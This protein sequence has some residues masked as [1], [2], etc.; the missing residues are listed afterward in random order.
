MLCMILHI[1]DLMHIHTLV[2]HSL[3]TVQ[4]SMLCNSKHS[5]GEGV[6][7]GPKAA[8]VC[9]IQWCIGA[10]RTADIHERVLDHLL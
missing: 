6:C 9:A 5:N 2:T 10:D 8:E 1:N 3:F 4:L 7:S